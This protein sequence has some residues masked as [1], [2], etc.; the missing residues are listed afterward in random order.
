MEKLVKLQPVASDVGSLTSK[1]STVG[2]K[3][4]GRFQT[5]TG[6]SAKRGGGEDHHGYKKP[7]SKNSHLSPELYS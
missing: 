2:G 1:V 3:P 7:G 6:P 5:E 4:Q